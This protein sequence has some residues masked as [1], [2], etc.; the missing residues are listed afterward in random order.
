MLADGTAEQTLHGQTGLALPR[1]AH[2]IGVLVV[3]AADGQQVD[4]L[5]VELLLAVDQAAHHLLGV[6]AHRGHLHVEV[7]LGVL[8]GAGDVHDTVHADVVGAET[9]AQVQVGE[10]H[11]VHHIHSLQVQR[12]IVGVAAKGDGS[13]LFEIEFFLDDVLDSEVVE[14][15]VYQVVAIEIERPFVEV[16]CA[17]RSAAVQGHVVAALGIHQQSE[18]SVGS[19]VDT[20]IHA[21][22]RGNL[23]YSRDGALNLYLGL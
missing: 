14:S 18:G 1:L 13:S 2:G 6:A 8:G 22:V 10:G 23:G 19:G 11:A 4:H 9:L 7:Y 5:L 15:M 12:S 20:E 21:Q 16:R 3:E 17:K